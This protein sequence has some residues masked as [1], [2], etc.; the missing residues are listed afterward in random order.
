MRVL[1]RRSEFVMLALVALAAQMLLSFGHTHARH[2]F[3]P[4]SAIACRT[5]VPPAAGQPCAPSHHDDGKDCSI[6]WSMGVASAAVLG[7]A[8]TLALP[9]DLVS[10]MPAQRAAL[11]VSAIPT[12][13]F[14][15]R[16]PPV[17]VS[18]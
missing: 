7:A 14:Q 15:P 6:C 11:D 4:A 8:F 16:G 12:A 2:A 18:A 10:S 3:D 1:R 9:F 13:A 5:V 17:L